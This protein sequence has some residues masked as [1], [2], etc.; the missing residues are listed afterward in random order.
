MLAA[1]GPGLACPAPDPIS[2]PPPTAAPPMQLEA[3]YLAI[4]VGSV[5]ATVSIFSSVISFR[6][7]APLLLVFLGIGLIAGEDGIL[8]IPFDNAPVAYLIG[9]VALALILFDSGFGT[10]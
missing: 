8:G 2:R 1:G 10:P 9:S 3:M 6:I 5:L 4:L 7:G